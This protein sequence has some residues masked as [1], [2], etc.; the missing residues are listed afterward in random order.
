MGFLSCRV[1]GVEFFHRIEGHCL[2]V[3]QIVLLSLL[4][5]RIQ[6]VESET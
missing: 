2:L 6:N 1:L 3:R 4:S 5:E